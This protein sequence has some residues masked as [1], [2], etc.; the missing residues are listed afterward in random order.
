MKDLPE[1]LLGVVTIV[2]WLCAATIAGAGNVSLLPV[3]DATISEKDL[4]SPQGSDTSLDSGTTG[5]VAGALKNRA[6]LKFNVAANIPSNAIVTSASL[7]MT[8]VQTPPL[9]M[10]LWFSLH[11]VFS[12][13]SESSVTWTNR[14]SPPAAWSAPGGAAPR[15]YSSSVTQSNLITGVSAFTFASNPAMVADV[16]DWLAIPANNFGWILICELEEL[17]K[18]VRK[19]GSR[20]APN[21]SVRPSLEVQFT[22]RVIAPSLTLL[23]QMNGQFQFQFNAESNR[24]YTVV[25]AGD[26]DTT[27]WMVL[28]NITPLPATT[29]ILVSDALLTGSNRFYRVRTP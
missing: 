28:T 3:E 23:P 9:A 18:S 14:F 22:L 15:D 7:T 4:S 6:L 10:N 19:F 11:K 24:D 29:T 5:P 26:F 1:R 2:V 16:Q 25:Y 12:D 27:N 17:E 21:S 8:I 13:W 20:E